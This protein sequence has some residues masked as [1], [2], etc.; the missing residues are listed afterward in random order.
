MTTINAKPPAYRVPPAG[1]ATRRPNSGENIAQV[2]VKGKRYRENAEKNRTVLSY[3]QKRGKFV[4]KIT[5][6]P[7]TGGKGRDIIA[8]HENLG[9]RAQ[10]SCF[11]K[12]AAA[13]SNL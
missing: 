8:T 6:Y 1:Q 7:F 5:K 10:I 2:G 3:P 4:Q 11:C 12:L 9:E 13:G